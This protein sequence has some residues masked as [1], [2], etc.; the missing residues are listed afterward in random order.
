MY[1]KI[2][3]TESKGNPTEWEKVFANCTC[4]KGLKSR[5]DRELLKL[6]NKKTKQLD[7]KMDEGLE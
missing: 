3:S 2:L 6:N 1:E 5:I 7:S 4:G